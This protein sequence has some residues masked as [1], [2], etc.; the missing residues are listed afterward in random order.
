MRQT[1]SARDRIVGVA[2]KPFVKRTLIA[3]V[4]LFVLF[5]VVGYLV[6]PGILKSKAEEIISQKLHRKTTIE[7]IEIHPYSLEATVRGFKMMEPDG[8]AVFVAFAELYANLETESL[9]RLAPVVREVRLVEPY[10]HSV[11]VDGSR[12]NISDIIE[13]INSQPPSEEPARFSVNNIAIIGGKIEFDD[14]PERTQHTI[15]ELK[16]GVPFVSNLPSYVEVFVEPALSAKV[17]GAPLALTGKARPFGETQEASIDLDFDAVDLTRFYN[18][19]PFEPAF[20]L[21]SVKLDLHVNASFHQAKG[22]APKL[23][24][25]G[26]STLKDLELTA[27]DGQPLIKL[28]QLDL[29]LGSADILANRIDVT[30]I[31]LRSPEVNIARNRRGEFNLLK[32]VPPTTEHAPGGASARE[33]SATDRD[34]GAKAKPPALDLKVAEVTV[35]GAV[36]RFA[37]EVPAKPFNTKIDKLDIT[38]RQFSLPGSAPATIEMSAHSEVGETIKHAGEFTLQ[39][40]AANGELQAAGIPLARYL[41][42]YV[43]A[44]A[45]EID[46]GNAS[47]SAKYSFAM[48]AAG[49]PNIKIEEAGSTLSDLTVRLPGEKRPVVT[50]EALTVANASA[51]LAQQEVR[52][53][54]ISSR[55]AKFALVRNKDGSLNVERLMQAASRVESK[56]VSLG[57]SPPASAAS[58][59]KPFVVSIGRL[60]IDKWSAR[61][62]D[63][64]MAPSVVTMVE[65]LTL[66]AQDLSTAAGARAKVD[67]RAGINKKGTL[68][69]GGTFGASPIHANLKLDL[70][71]VDALPLQPYFT[72]RVN[73]LLT[74]AALT[75]RGTLVLDE[76]KGGGLKGGFRGEFNVGDLASVDKIN[77]NDI[78]KWKSLF[79]GG[80]DLKL[81]PFALSIEQIALSDFYSRVIV[82]PEGRINLQDVMRG[83]GGEAKSVT[84]AAPAP[85]ND[86]MQGKSAP[87]ADSEKPQ[88]QRAVQPAGTVPPIRIGKLTLQGGRVNFTDN[89]IR[90]NYTANLVELGGSVTGLSS[91]ASTTADVDLRGQVNN[92]PLAIVGKINPLKGDLAID[93]KADVKGMELAPLTP[94]SGKYVGYGIEKGKLS[95]DVNYKIENRKLT[96]ENRLVLDQ[97]TFG[98]KIESPSATKLPVLLAVA[99]LRDRHGVIDINLPVGGSLDD[100]QF[101]VGG[102]IIKVIINLITK[103]VTAPFALLGSLFGG[104]EELSYLEFDAGR[105]A[106]SEAGEAKL[107]SLAKALADRPSLKLEIAGRVDPATDREGLRRASIDRKVRALK[108]NDTVKKGESVD[109]ASIVV[110]AEEYPELLN[111]VYK[112]EKFPKPRNLVGLQK[113]L[114]VEEMEKLMTTNAQVYDEDLV[115]LGNQRAQSVKDWLLKNG[116]VPQE[117][118]FL[119]APK[120][121]ASGAKD[122]EDAKD[123]SKETGKGK[124]SRVEFSLK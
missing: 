92:A 56:Q 61:I 90:P 22:A 121:G 25:K 91:D 59:D 57:T 13:L 75:S 62:E 45:G 44:F 5:G 64:T 26:T 124:A 11:H 66:K 63:Q 104:G 58:S 96:A 80:V 122:K 73:I 51:D 89:F 24:V 50:V 19:I 115:E 72:D 30:R 2:R 54:E 110:T 117:R 118:V 68:T 10:V 21:P 43:P 94:Y 77:S 8:K 120:L 38:V 48:D 111:R 40:L 18:Y 113:D 29:A 108:L 76:A 14:R 16:I 35:D 82:S 81:A 83:Q 87:E 20:K 114:P 105:Y 95:F 6:L 98:E 71:G 74:S 67:V 46:K 47:A 65:P 60:D 4:A 119:L 101:S 103:A 53:G 100:P 1:Q 41:P 109:P 34:E 79:F 84:E 99:L 86:A 15:E 88:Q 9:I 102:I 33:A 70:K 52:V 42:H 69:A 55:N 37:D 123:A 36:I 3:L 112:E 85:A 32:L 28:P 97:L 106:I 31:S 27:L 23:V 7:A 116:Q 107:R 93:I 78:L 12:Y 49:H 39:P 17:N